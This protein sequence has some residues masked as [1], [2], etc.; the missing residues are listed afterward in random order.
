[1]SSEVLAGDRYENSGY[2]VVIIGD[3]AV[4]HGSF[5]DVWKGNWDDPVERR[6][7]VVALRFLRQIMVQNVREKLLKRLHPM[8]DESRGAGNVPRTSIIAIVDTY[9]SLYLTFKLPQFQTLLTS[10]HC[11]RIGLF[12]YITFIQSIINVEQDPDIGI[13]LP[14]LLPISMDMTPQAVAPHLQTLASLNTILEDLHSTDKIGYRVLLRDGLYWIVLLDP[15]PILVSDPSVAHNFLYR[16][17]WTT[18]AS[19]SSSPSTCSHWCSPHSAASSWQ[20]WYFASRDADVARTLCRSFF[21][22]EG[23]MWIEVAAFLKPRRFLDSVASLAT[24]HNEVDD[25]Y[26]SPSTYFTNAG[27]HHPT[28]TSTTE[29]HGSHT[30][31]FRSNHSSGCWRL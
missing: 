19:S 25:D 17:P 16:E 26:I 5:S 3:S 6:P 9:T 15:I 1:M 14:E 7:R 10:S 11:Y 4:A 12:P 20:L 31:R 23:G 29:K 27:Y 18:T 21:W 24:Y 2:E 13:L 22:S 28:A 8:L 30:W